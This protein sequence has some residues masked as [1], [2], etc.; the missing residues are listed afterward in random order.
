[1]KV[2]VVGAGFAGACAAWML[3][4]RSDATITILERDA[5]PG[6]MLRTLSTKEGLTFEYGPRVVSVFRGTPDILPFLRRFLELEERQIYQGTRLRPEYPVIPFPVDLQS[7]RKLPTGDQIER[8]LAEIRAAG[9]RPREGNLREYLESSVGP[10]LTTLA[11]EG[12]NLKFWGRKL[13]DMPAEW[14]KLRRLER[15]AEEGDFRLPSQAPHYYPV[16]GFNPLF[17]KMLEGFDV[18]T[19]TRV[20]RVDGDSSGAT[21]VTDSGDLR[22]DLVISTAPIDAL[23]GFRFGRLEW[24]G[25]RIETEVVDKGNLGTAPDGIPFAWLYTPWLETPVCRTTDFGV[26]HHGPE[27]SEPAVVLK[28]IVDSSVSMYPVWWEVDRFYRYLEA[29]SQIPSLIPLGRLGFYKYVTVDTTF[30]MVERLMDSLDAYLAADPSNRFEI[31]RAIRG[32]WQN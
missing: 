19:N 10:T 1:M 24:T 11:F 4:E 23:L 21:V 32:D 17:D 28:E 5:V 27:R 22:A 14:G 8:E 31:L 12:F 16:G 2:V 15:I 3:R 26:I 9:A 18:R 30:A 7:L 25:Y 13:E 6:G 29:A 20:E